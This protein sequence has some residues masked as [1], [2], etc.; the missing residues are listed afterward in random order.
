MVNFKFYMLRNK[1]IKEYIKNS[2][3]MLQNLKKILY[4]LDHLINTAAWNRGMCVTLTPVS[5]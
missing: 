5:V 4:T 3:Q 2:Y 1:K